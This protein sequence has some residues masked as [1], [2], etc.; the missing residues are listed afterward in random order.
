MVC[1]KCIYLLRLLVIFVVNRNC[2]S[3]F[4]ILFNIEQIQLKF[5]ICIDQWVKEIIFHSQRSSLT[6]SWYIGYRASSVVVVSI[7]LEVF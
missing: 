1:E 5:Q 2:D 3:Y 4:N 6:S 7:V